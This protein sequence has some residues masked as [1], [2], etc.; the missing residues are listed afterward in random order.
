MGPGLQA[1]SAK[2]L[3]PAVAPGWDAS[4]PTSR[5]HG[6]VAQCELLRQVVK[7]C[8]QKRVAIDVGAHIGL[9]SRNLKKYFADVLAFEPIKE[10][11][12]CFQRNVAGIPNIWLAQFALGDVDAVVDMR[13][14]E[15]SNS[16]MWHAMP[17]SPRSTKDDDRA[18]YDVEMRRLDGCPLKFCDLL[19]IDVEGLE[20][21]VLLG[22]A[23]TVQTHRPVIVF[24][25]N[26]LGK[27]YYG[28]HW[29]D[30]KVLLRAWKYRLRMRWRKDEVWLPA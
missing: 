4:F 25:D 14:P 20:G 16:G 13:R 30:P 27:K 7:M 2:A 28:E 21:R 5:V 29:V 26:G 18:Q 9:W 15:Q 3:H 23:Q 10:N 12:E 19:K 8:P 6:E 17:Q 1:D 11:A 22:A 24:E